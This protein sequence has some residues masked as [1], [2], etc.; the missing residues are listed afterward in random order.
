LI[1]NFI[2]KLNDLNKT[3]HPILRDESRK[4]NVFGVC[5]T[6]RENWEKKERKE[7]KY[8]EKTERK[9]EKYKEK[10]EGDLKEK[11]REY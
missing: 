4:Q 10:T 1:Y 2:F 6:E 5:F 11:E 7:E 8:K 9:E 3:F